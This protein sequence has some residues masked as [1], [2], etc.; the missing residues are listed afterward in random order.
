MLAFFIFLMTNSASAQY[1]CTPP[2]SDHKE[3]VS[4]CGDDRSMVYTQKNEKITVIHFTVE[5]P[6]KG[7]VRNVTLKNPGL[8][9]A[10]LQSS[11]FVKNAAV[12]KEITKI[13]TLWNTK[14]LRVSVD[15]Y[16]LDSKTKFYTAAD[17]KTKLPADK[18]PHAISRNVASENSPIMGAGVGRA[19]NK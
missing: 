8:T 12:K 1:K 6:A 7:M 19:S 14:K 2:S 17:L 3:I 4:V 15:S 9:V 11:D 5:N 18:M 13:E 16:E 10:Q